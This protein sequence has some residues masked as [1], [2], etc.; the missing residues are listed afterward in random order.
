MDDT[1]ATYPAADTT[2]EPFEQPQAQEAAATEPAQTPQPQAQDAATTEPAQTEPTQAQEAADPAAQLLAAAGT[3]VEFVS[4]GNNS[5]LV[6]L[7]KE[8]AI[9]QYDLDTDLKFSASWRPAEGKEP[10]GY[11]SEDG[12]TI[13]PEAGDS[14]DFTAH[15]GNV[16]VSWNAGGYWTIQFSGLESKKEVVETYF[17]AAMDSTGGLTISSA[18]CNTFKQY[19]VAG[20]TQTEDLILLHIPKAKVGERE[21]IT[22]NISNL[23][24]FGMTLRAYKD[25]VANKYFMRAFGFAKVSSPAA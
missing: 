7:I 17:D 25:A 13:H 6:K 21:D 3:G 23:Q 5:D 22:W 18:E 4:D 1:N 14:N 8:A 24:N 19:V 9:F 10:F 16:V 2:A 11:F 15:N 20:L 12:I